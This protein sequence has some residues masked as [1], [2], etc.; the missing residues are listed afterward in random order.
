MPKKEKIKTAQEVE[1][2]VAE[3]VKQ[4]A[5][6][7]VVV[8]SK[9]CG[10]VNMHSLGVD[11]KLDFPTCT[12]DNG[13][14][15]DHYGKHRMQ[16]EGGREYDRIYGKLIDIKYTVVEGDVWWNDAAGIPVEKIQIGQMPS[17]NKKSELLRAVEDLTRG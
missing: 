11:G 6:T 16:V 15:G 5:E 14:S 3:E 1:T 12:L 9:L 13:H 17:R 10:H 2:S 4:E 7:P 8:T